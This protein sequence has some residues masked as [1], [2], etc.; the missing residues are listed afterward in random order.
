MVNITCFGDWHGNTSYAI[1][2]LKNAIGKYPDSYLVHQ[3]DFGFT[4]AKIYAAKTDSL[5]DIELR[6]YVHEINEYLDSVDKNI[7]VVLG[8]HENYPAI[9]E[10]FRYHGLYNNIIDIKD[11]KHRVILKEEHLCLNEKLDDDTRKHITMYRYLY[12]TLRRQH[13]F[14]NKYIDF[15]NIIDFLVDK[16]EEN[17]EKE[18][19]IVKRIIRNND[20]K[21]FYNTLC[22]E[23]YEN[24]RIRKI[25]P[26]FNILT[27]NERDF[28]DTLWYY[29]GCININSG[30]KEIG[31]LLY[32]TGDEK[33]STDYYD[34]Q[35]FIISSLFPRIKIIP[36]GHVWSWENATLASFG[37]ALSINK[38]HLERMK[39]WCE[40]ESPTCE[41]AD[42]FIKALPEKVDVL[43]THDIP[44]QASCKL[45]N[46]KDQKSLTRSWGEDIVKENTEVT[47]I[48]EKVA[49]FCNPDRIVSGHHHKRK[50]IQLDNGSLVH[51]LDCDRS[52]INYNYINFD[53]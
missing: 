4:D 45:Y 43:L 44:Y 27:K 5:G 3:G 33:I 34:D 10:V 24:D 1:K 49:I 51:I 2:S 35:G 19:S 17:Y 9:D 41:Q 37:G 29:E 6:G 48:I 36:R 50:D 20:Y 8:N 11:N 26:L 52:N 13:C 21:L 38:K 16:Q 14:I 46:Q 31:Q 18:G 47:K 32:I 15:Y 7:Y 25:S 53:I 40:E 22:Q 12:D 23:G 39:T 28:F 30:M 42:R